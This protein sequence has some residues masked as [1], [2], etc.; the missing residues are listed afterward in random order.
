MSCRVKNK[1]LIGS[2]DMVTG[3]IVIDEFVKFVDG[4]VD[5]DNEMG[6]TLRSIIPPIL[7]GYQN[8]N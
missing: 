6:R 1:L 7:W 4:S 3:V 2:V 8:L 5:G